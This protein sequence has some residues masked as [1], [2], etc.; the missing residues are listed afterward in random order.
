[1]SSGFFTKAEMFKY[2]GERCDEQMPG[3]PTCRAWTRF[4]LI[5]HMRDEDEDMRIQFE[6]EEIE[7]RKAVTR[8][9]VNTKIEEARDG[10]K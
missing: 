1:M 9:I 4:D 7:A 8:F 6:N 2:V 10:R 3:C 5:N